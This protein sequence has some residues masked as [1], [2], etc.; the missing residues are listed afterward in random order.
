MKR[1]SL[2]E[3]EEATSQETEA[4][5][6]LANRRSSEKSSTFKTRLSNFQVVENSTAAPVKVTPDRDPHFKNKLASFQVTAE[7]TPAAPEGKPPSIPESPNGG[8]QEEEGERLDFKAKLAAFRQVEAQATAPPSEPPTIKMAAPPKPEPIKAKPS[9][10][11]RTVTPVHQPTTAEPIYANSSVAA[12]QQQ[13]LAPYL[14]PRPSAA[15]PES[16]CTEDE[17]IRSLSPHGTPSP[18]SP[19]RVEPDPAIPQ[20]ESYDYEYISI[21]LSYLIEI[22]IH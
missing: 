12:Q 9:V 4:A 10:S 18:T 7:S 3:R 16:D 13:Q 17:G 22:S 11:V 19:T 21:N 15:D 5:R 20:P 8:G 14:V 6:L 1:R 2:F